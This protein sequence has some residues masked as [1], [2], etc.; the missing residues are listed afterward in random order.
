MAK[1][2]AIK[3]AL[4]NYQSSG[5]NLKQTAKLIIK[6]QNKLVFTVDILNSENYECS[7]WVHVYEQ[8]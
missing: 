7:A 6:I 1:I 4:L 8:I 2:N 5:H 3:E